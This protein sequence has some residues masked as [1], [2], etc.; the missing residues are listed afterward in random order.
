MSSNYNGWCNIFLTI[1]NFFF[2]PSKEYRFSPQSAECILTF[3]GLLNN[4]SK[5]LLLQC[6]IPIVK[7]SWFSVASQRES[8]C[9]FWITKSSTDWCQCIFL[10]FFVGSIAP[11]TLHSEL[12]CLI[13][14]PQSVI[15]IL[16]FVSLALITPLHLE[17]PPP[18]NL[19]ILYESHIAF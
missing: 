19:V 11:D 6:H 16:A 4:L 17:H 10:E 9:A 8:V 1:F 18:S 7:L 3:A 2:G 14:M 12:D 5:I 13:T 15:W